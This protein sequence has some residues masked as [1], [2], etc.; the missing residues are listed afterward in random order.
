[1]NNPINYPTNFDFGK[2]WQ[3]KIVP[4]LNNKKLLNAIR[5]GVN[6]YLAGFPACKKRYRKDTAPAYYT[7]SDGYYMLMDRKNEEMLEKLRNENKLPEKYLRLESKIAE[8]D[9]EEYEEDDVGCKLQERLWRMKDKILKPYTDWNAICNDLETYVLMHSCHWWAPTFEL[10]L[11]K[12]VEPDEKWHVR[13]GEKHS[14]VINKDD[15]KCFDL[16]YWAHN[17]LYNHVFNDPLPDDA[18]ND[19]TLGGR[20]AYIDSAE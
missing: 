20:Q 19:C 4:H 7:S 13:I 9:Q 2:H 6:S 10:I 17:R 11:A 8:M 1:M 16:L 18:L 5:K 14:T 12:L 3:T 15:T